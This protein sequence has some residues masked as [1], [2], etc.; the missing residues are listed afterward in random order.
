MRL[1]RHMILNLLQFTKRLWFTLTS[2]KV[3]GKFRSEFSL[4]GSASALLALARTEAGFFRLFFDYSFLRIRYFLSQIVA[5]LNLR[6]ARAMRGA[7]EVAR[8][9]GVAASVMFT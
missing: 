4:L 3:T 2:R 7:T 5:A 8:R 6:P 9:N 1:S